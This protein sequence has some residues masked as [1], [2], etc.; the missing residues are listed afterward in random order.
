MATI[1]Y[2]IDLNTYIHK[3]RKAFALK[4]HRDAFP[5]TKIFDKYK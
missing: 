5:S 3:F 4:T 1:E 2:V